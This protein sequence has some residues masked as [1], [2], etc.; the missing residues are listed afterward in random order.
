VQARVGTVVFAAADPKRG[1]LGGCLDLAH[2]PSAHH[3][4][5]V[6]AGL[7]A[8]AASRQLERWFQRRRRR[9]RQGIRP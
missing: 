5:R 1:A 3:H 8:E 6:I 9:P 2:H 4:M 7:E